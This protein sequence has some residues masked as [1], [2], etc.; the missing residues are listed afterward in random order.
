MYVAV[1]K[2]AYD[3]YARLLVLHMPAHIPGKPNINVSDMPSGGG[4][5]AANYAA[6]VAAKDGTALL[7]P[8]KPIA[9]KQF[10]TPNVKYDASTFQWVGSMVDAP[11]ALMVWHTAP[12]KTSDDARQTRIATGST[13][14]GGETA[15]FRSVINAVLGTKFKVIAGFKGMSNIFLGLNMC[16]IIR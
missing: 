10:L 16:R 4:V 12:A 8:P 11:G 2:G 15:I 6:N 5:V 3:L 7:V 1:G 14:W 13:G 9:M